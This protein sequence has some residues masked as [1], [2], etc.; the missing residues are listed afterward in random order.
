MGDRSVSRSRNSSP[1]SSSE[2]ESE[3]GV[4]SKKNTDKKNNETN[5]NVRN[6]KMNG[7][8]NKTPNTPLTKLDRRTM[9]DSLDASESSEEEPIGM[10]KDQFWAKCKE[11]GFSDDECEELIKSVEEFIQSNVNLDAYDEDNIVQK[12]KQLE[13]AKQMP[14]DTSYS[15]TVR[16]TT[17][18]GTVAYLTS[19][20]FGKLAS[21]LTIAGTGSPYGSWAFLIAGI[22]NPLLSEPLVNAIRNGGAAYASPDGI[23]YTDYRTASNRL[24]KAKYFEDQI[25]IKKWKKECARIVDE[26]IKREQTGRVRFSSGVSTINRDMDDNPIDDKKNIIYRK[27]T[28]DSVIFRARIRA[29]L[30]DEMPFFLFAFHYTISGAAAP[31]AKAAFSPLVATAIDIGISVPLGMSAGATTGML[32]NFLRRKIQGAKIVEGMPSQVKEAHLAL[33]SANF[34]AWDARRFK[35]FQTKALIDEQL[36]SLN[37]KNAANTGD[38]TKDIEALNTCKEKAEQEWKNADKKCNKYRRQHDRYSSQLKRVGANFLGLVSAYSGE[39]SP[40][41]KPMEGRRAINRTIAKVISYPLSLSVSCI[42][43]S[44]VIPATLAAGAAILSNSSSISHAPA[45]PGMGGDFMPAPAHINYTDTASPISGG[46]LTANIMAG[47]PLIIGFILRTQLLQ[48]IVERC[49]TKMEWGKDIPKED[50]ADEDDSDIVGSSDESG[51]EDSDE[52]FQSSHPS[53]A[54]KENGYFDEEAGNNPYPKSLTRNVGKI[55]TQVNVDGEDENE[56]NEEY[57]TPEDSSEIT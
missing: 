5:S 38:V 55:L 49:L 56:I 23:A 10:T 42:Y 20:C 27:T 29:F 21:S 45:M 52:E 46:Y 9:S 1:S 6:K 4:R 12:K 30:S 40:E 32:Q 35:H 36:E 34:S 25:G 54:R 7:N 50:N 47:F 44:M 53:S 15:R 11:L 51:D 26:V 31:F 48:G 57:S 24:E 22:L 43:N 33:A 28:E 18:A 16:T 41:S 14:H 39:K 8:R 37:K 2:S 17:L 13:T 19:F 3:D